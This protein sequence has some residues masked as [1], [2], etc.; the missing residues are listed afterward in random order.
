MVI[1]ARS[2]E[3][4]FEGMREGKTRIVCSTGFSSLD[5]LLKLSKRYLAV[6]TGFPGSGKSEFVD[7][8]VSNLALMYGWKTLYFSPENNPLHEH[9]AKISERYVGKSIRE[10]SDEEMQRSLDFVEE[11]FTWMDPETP[12]LTTLF[13]YAVDV[14]KEKGLDCLVLDPWNGIHHDRGMLREDEYLME[15]LTKISVWARR[16]NILVFI[17]A[18]PK[19]I[20]IGQDRKQPVPRVDDISG[21]VMW[22]NK[23]DYAIV[24]H[25]ENR[26]EN[27][28]DV[29]TQKI[30]QKWMGNY[31]VVRL[32]YQYGSGRFKDRDAKDFYLPHE[33]IPPF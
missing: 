33:I 30:K 13:K 9:I 10:F 18:H 12:T 6:V 5:P 19:T 15:S 31:G 24:C 20:P 32:D 22:W 29:Y 2:L 16:N 21:G 4:E 28:M 11:Y 3:A 17:V 7:A 27:H 1:K 26:K 14:K 25:R 8:I 23:V